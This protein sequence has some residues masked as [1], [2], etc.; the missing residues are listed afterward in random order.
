MADTDCRTPDELSN[1]E[2]SERAVRYMAEAL[3]SPEARQ[4]I[5]EAF[6]DIAEGHTTPL[7]EYLGRVWG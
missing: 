2:P 7:R 4:Q 1:R 5:F 6:D 3:K